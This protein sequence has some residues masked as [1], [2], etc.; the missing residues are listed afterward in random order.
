MKAMCHCHKYAACITVTKRGKMY[1]SNTVSVCHPH[2]TIR[3]LT[4]E[5]FE[6]HVKEAIY[7]SAT[8]GP[9]EIEHTPEMVEQIIRP[10]GLLDPTIDVRPIEGQIDDLIDEIN[11]RIKKNERVLITT[12]TKKMSEDLTDYL[13][14]IGIKVQYLHSEIKTLERIEIIRELRLGTYDVL[15]GINFLREGIDIPEVSLVTILDADKEGFLRSERALIQTIGRAA[16]NSNGH[17]IM[18]ADR[19]T[20]SMTKA[21]GETKRRRDIQRAYNE[22]HGITPTTIKKEIRDVIRATQVAEETES[23]VEKLTQ[24]KKLTKDEKNHTSCH[25]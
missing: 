4:F 10:T 15:V 22:K 5:E 17:V 8:P 23:Y 25:A 6:S 11:E 12:L 1:S 14:E 19:M 21:I 24:G 18:Y 9:Y 3:P 2:S 7:V 13:K 16:R 20:D